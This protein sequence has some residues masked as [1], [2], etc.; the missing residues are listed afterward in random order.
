MSTMILK[1][2]RVSSDKIV[3]EGFRFRYNTLEEA[4]ND[5]LHK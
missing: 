4:L 1:G 2:S 3:S 5:V